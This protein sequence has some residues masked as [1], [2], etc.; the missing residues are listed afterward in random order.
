M[1]LSELRRKRLKLFDESPSSAP[2]G[3]SP[4]E[5]TIDLTMESEDISPS[6]RTLQDAQ[7]SM[8]QPAVD[9]G[10]SSSLAFDE[11]SDALT[12]RAFT[13][14]ILNRLFLGCDH[15]HLGTSEKVLRHFRCIMARPSSDT[16]SGETFKARAKARVVE[17]VNL[18]LQCLDCSDHVCFACTGP[19][20]N[21]PEQSSRQS[22]VIQGISIGPHCTLDAISLI[23]LIL[24]GFDSITDEKFVRTPKK[25]Q[26]KRIA[27]S[28]VGYGYNDTDLEDT[29]LNPL[30]PSAFTG[31]GCTLDGLAVPPKTR[32][33]IDSPEIRDTS[34]GD[35]VLT[36]VFAA[37]THLL[38]T[39]DQ[40]F[41]DESPILR[42]LL[43]SSNV[44]YKAAAL[45][46]TGSLDDVIEKKE[47]YSS[48]FS[49]LHTLAI[50][51]ELALHTL[52]AERTPTNIDQSLLKTSLGQPSLP[53]QPLIETRRPLSAWISGFCRAAKFFLDWAQRNENAAKDPANKE[54]IT[55]SK[56]IIELAD[57][58][59]TSA[60]AKNEEE[61]EMINSRFEWQK[62]LAFSGVEDELM[63]ANN[64]YGKEA[65]ET[66]NLRPV[67]MKALI[68]DLEI[69]HTSLPPDIFVRYAE[70]RPDL[71]KILIVGPGDSPYEH[72]L[73]E[74]DLFA[75]EAYPTVPPKMTFRTTSNGT[76]H[77][78]PNLY[79]NGFVC[80][81]LLGTWDGPGWRMG[82]STV[83]QIL[84]SIQAMIFCKDPW[85]NEPGRENMAE[86]PCSKRYNRAVQSLTVRHGI[87]EWLGVKTKLS[88]CRRRAQA[89][90]STP[91]PPPPPPPPMP[92]AWLPPPPK[93]FLSYLPGPPATVNGP[94]KIDPFTFPINSM[95]PIPNNY[96]STA[97]FVNE[98]FP[99][100]PPGA[101]SSH[102]VTLNDTSNPGHI[103]GSNA[104]PSQSLAADAKSQ[105]APFPLDHDLD[106]K[107]TQDATSAAISAHL[108]FPRPQ[109]L[110]LCTAISATETP[111]T[112]T[113]PPQSIDSSQAHLKTN[114][115]A[116]HS[117]P[118]TSSN[119]A[120]VESTHP[121]LTEP[122]PPLDFNTLVTLQDMKVENPISPSYL[123]SPPEH[124]IPSPDFW[125]PVPALHFKH[126]AD[127]I[128][129]TVFRWTQMELP[130]LKHWLGRH[131]DLCIASS[132]D[133]TTPSPPTT[134]KQIVPGSTSLK[135]PQAGQDLVKGLLTMLERLDFGMPPTE[136]LHEYED[137][138]EKIEM[139]E[140]VR[141]E[142]EEEE[143]ER[144]RCRLAGVEFVEFKDGVPGHGLWPEEA[145]DD[146]DDDDDEHEEEDK[147][148]REDG[149][150]L[151]TAPDP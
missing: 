49:F 60:P 144:E 40:N 3:S 48:L 63:F 121:P 116:E 61:A 91:L 106:G 8:M 93:D 108:S 42:V 24:C 87:L 6:A 77:F 22:V 143:A 150:E 107:H 44:M 25:R 43:R 53:L 15:R 79:Q 103:V 7:A 78:N 27:T 122:L 135:T 59:F 134:F 118:S 58:I 80:L 29:S 133:I 69:L 138:Q 110:A 45:L 137:V 125:N 31:Q 146:D 35:E 88:S 10:A 54:K 34:K 123:L 41:V 38:T 90:M 39:L 112:S 66:T 30:P 83:L 26:A 115:E 81:S 94:S 16:D 101:V 2:T 98:I 4:S 64:V 55:V 124:P 136:I 140:E 74:F 33:D 141:Q 127:A 56:Q 46:G 95:P 20:T 19:V 99:L 32:S 14:P 148:V 84:I 129:Q 51:P 120:L 17:S 145:S 75:S 96:P 18:T 9:E 139:E 111:S 50:H 119:E 71:M 113:P 82:Q 142:Y 72:G 37:L 92:I 68:K 131:Q 52:H 100:H 47:L 23:W 1:D 97:A 132:D 62:D 105:A 70:S 86:D 102:A 89:T 85:C 11:S 13:L 130:D 147:E 151:T 67:R 128:L 126:N 12:L 149:E 36:K 5:Q 28:G 57:F 117:K 104:A 65:R 73:F 114:A 109:S 21:N 76:A